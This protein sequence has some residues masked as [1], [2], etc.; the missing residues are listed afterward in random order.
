MATWGNMSKQFL[1]V[2][3]YHEVNDPA[4]FQRQLDWMA[5]MYSFVNIEEVDDAIHYNKPLPPNPL[6]ITFDDAHR[7][8]YEQGMPVLSSYKIPAI[9]FAITSIVGTSTPYWWDV[10]RQSFPAHWT[11]K[12]KSR[13]M[14]R[15]KQ[16]PNAERVAL[17]E[18][19]SRQF[20]TL[21]ENQLT[22]SE[23]GEM[24][25]NG[26]VIGNHT[27]THPMLDHC[28]ND[29]IQQELSVASQQLNENDLSG[30]VYFAYPNGNASSEAE[31]MLQQEGI[32]LAFLFDH[33]IN[34]RKP[35]P[36]RISRLSVN[37][38][39]SVH[40]L[41]FILSGWHTRLLPV[42]RLLA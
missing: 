16:L 41:Q 40:K 31:A 30:A 9:V 32:R 10:I 3:C 15:I 37:S 20:P 14:N 4:N 7:S 1:T 8:V 21:I 34:F 19:L 25:R 35:N 24:E 39:T 38:N 28:S 33:R 6:L 23:V 2:L 42:R 22:W 26:I 29:I 13:E 27:H 18:E 5:A 12:Q 11:A 17:I 36:Y